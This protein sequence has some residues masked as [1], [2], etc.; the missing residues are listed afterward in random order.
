MVT[1]TSSNDN[2]FSGSFGDRIADLVRI[3]HRKDNG[4][5]AIDKSISFVIIFAIDKP[6]KTSEPSIASDKFLIEVFCVM[7][8]CFSGG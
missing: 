5:F 6:I 1:S 2:I 4:F 3:S 7:N 8:F